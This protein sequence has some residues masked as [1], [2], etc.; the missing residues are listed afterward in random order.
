MWKIMFQNI[1]IGLTKTPSSAWSA[2]SCSS[3]TTAQAFRSGAVEGVALLSREDGSG[4]AYLAGPVFENQAVA[5][6]RNYVSFRASLDFGFPIF[7]FLAFTGMNGCHLRTAQY[8]GTDGYYKVGPLRE[9][10]VALPEAVIESSA[11]DVPQ[12]MRLA[13]TTGWNAFG[14]PQSDT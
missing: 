14:I 4:E 13:F 1:G 11:A 10:L 2:P 12:A 7:V 6:I 9:D 3:K 5:T 8:P